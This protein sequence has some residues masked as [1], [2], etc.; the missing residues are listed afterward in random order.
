MSTLLFASSTTSTRA[1]ERSLMRSATLPG[2]TVD[3]KGGSGHVL[4]PC[5][6]CR[7]A[8]PRPMRIQRTSQLVTAAVVVV[9]VLAIVCT[10]V[11]GQYRAVERKA[12]ETRRRMFH[13]TEQLAA[14]SDR[15]TAAVRAYAATGDRR[16]HAA[17]RR[18]VEDDRNREAAVEGL[19]ELELLPEE[20][21]LLETAKRNSDALVHLENEAFAAVEEN[22]TARAIQIVY[23]PEYEAAKTSIMDP[24]AECRR[25]LDRRLTTEAT[26]IAERAA[27]LTA[28]AISALVLSAVATL[29]ALLFFYGRRVVNPLAQL[30]S[31]LR[32]LVAK[33]SDARIGHQDD[34]SELGEL[35]RSMES[36]RVA[37]DTAERQHRV[38]TALAEVGEALQGVEEPEAFGSRLLA[39]LVPLLGGGRGAFHLLDE[40]DGRFHLVAGYAT[41]P[42]EQA[43]SFA[44]GE[45]VAGQAAVERKVLVVTDVPAGYFPIRSSLGEAPPLVLV[46]AP[47]RVGEAVLAV[48]E[49]ASFRELDEQQR[50]LLDEA[51]GLVAL[52]LEVLRRHLRTRELL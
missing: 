31:S 51:A 28:V 13:L 22:D 8:R 9:S 37:V 4:R 33:K 21:A 10:V 43:A 18:E 24:I 49:V 15:L 39:R 6:G 34:D 41:E 45:G 26:R 16:H 38:K 7:I 20:L 2:E 25:A 44:P 5:R 29:G 42:G 1:S 19:R 50:A 30:S 23:G 40:T 11:A 17:F 27:L 32:D 36:Y 35:A 14:G 46:A 52:H 3:F 48:I 47:I 12:Y